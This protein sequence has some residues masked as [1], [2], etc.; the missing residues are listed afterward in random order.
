MGGPT[1]LAEE[2]STRKVTDGIL[3][4]VMAKAAVDL[5]V[6]SAREP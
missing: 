2:R 6:G 4:V 5:G 1:L 3:V